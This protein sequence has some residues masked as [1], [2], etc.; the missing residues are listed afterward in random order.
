MIDRMAYVYKFSSGN[1]TGILQK[2]VP[3]TDWNPVRPA[4]YTF[5]ETGMPPIRMSEKEVKDNYGGL[6]LPGLLKLI[7][8]I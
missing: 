1:R 4:M 5:F 3:D 2:E 6:D 8:L 7:G